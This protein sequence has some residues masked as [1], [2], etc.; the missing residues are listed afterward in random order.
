MGIMRFRSAEVQ[1]CWSMDLRGFENRIARNYIGIATYK[2]ILNIS[3]R[4]EITPSLENFLSGL[5]SLSENREKLTSFNHEREWWATLKAFASKGMF[6]EEKEPFVTCC[7]SL[8]NCAM[9]DLDWGAGKPI[10]VMSANSGCFAMCEVQPAQSGGASLYF[11]LTGISWI[12]SFLAQGT[13]TGWVRRVQEREF[14]ETL[15]K[16]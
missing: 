8:C 12:Q 14:R 15:T 6:L 2:K 1:L 4:K 9:I 13:P 5:R 3:C 7:A 10:G 11:N 16:P